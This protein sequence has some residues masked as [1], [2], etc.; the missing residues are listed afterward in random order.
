VTNRPNVAVRLIPLKFFFRHF[1]S[2]P[3]SLRR[4]QIVSVTTLAVV[5]TDD[6]KPACNSLAYQQRLE[7]L[8][9][10]SEPRPEDLELVMR[11]PRIQ[12]P[13][14]PFR[15]GLAPYFRPR[16]SHSPP[17]QFA[18]DSRRSEDRF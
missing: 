18:P 3:R 2:A 14:S 4:D 1:L 11:P 6:L 12:N 15:Q 7:S 9:L 5:S 13:V 16:I 8:Y 17:E 10:S